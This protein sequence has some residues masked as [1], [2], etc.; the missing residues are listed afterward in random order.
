[1]AAFFVAFFAVF[2]AGFLVV[3]FA[4]FLAVFF[5]ALRG[6]ISARARNNATASASV[7]SA[8]SVPRGTV[9]FVVLSVTYGPYRPSSTRTGT[10]E[11]G[12]SPSSA[13]GGFC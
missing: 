13:S 11:S 9:A 12:C 2:F 4:A 6:P 7:S 5:A 10:F 8:G 3:F 1:M